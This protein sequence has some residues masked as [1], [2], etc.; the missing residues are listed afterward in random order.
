MFRCAVQANQAPAAGV[1]N[2][3]G[4]SEW[5]QSHVGKD[6]SSDYPTKPQPQSMPDQA[7]Q[8]RPDPRKE[9]EENV[10]KNVSFLFDPTS[11]WAPDQLHPRARSRGIHA[12]PILM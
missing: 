11:S 8:G 9:F 2:V 10:L 4:G 3:Q 7:K 12:M 6:L 1:V 5:W